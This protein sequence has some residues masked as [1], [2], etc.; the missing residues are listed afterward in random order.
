MNNKSVIDVL[1]YFNFLPGQI[2]NLKISGGQRGR[3]RDGEGGWE[4]CVGMFEF[5]VGPFPGTCTKCLR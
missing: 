1:S 5:H 3:G 4:Q 2:A